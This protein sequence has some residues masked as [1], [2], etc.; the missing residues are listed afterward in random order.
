MVRQSIQKADLSILELAQLISDIVIEDYGTHNYNAFLSVVLNK[1]SQNVNDI[2]EL[3]KVHKI[4]DQDLAE[5]F[6]YKNTNS[7]RN[8]KDG[9]KRLEAGL[10][11]FYN[12]INNKENENL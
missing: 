4:K 11:K 10:I 1:L 7:F 5:W 6:G 9:K 8:A 3:K 2:S 12:H